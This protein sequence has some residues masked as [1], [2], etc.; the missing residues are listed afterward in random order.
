MILN[1]SKKKGE[2]VK[3]CGLKF[4]PQIFRPRFSTH[5]FQILYF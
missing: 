4:E 5:Q 3:C 2:I 1:K